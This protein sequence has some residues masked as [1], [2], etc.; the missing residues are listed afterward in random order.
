MRPRLRKRYTA[1]GDHRVKQSREFFKLSPDKPKAILE[2]LYLKVVTPGAELFT[3]PGDKEAVGEAKK[4]RANFC[5]ATVGLEPG[6]ILQSVFDDDITCTVKGERW[7]EF[8]GQEQSLSSSAL[9]I[10]HEK[11]LRLVS[12]RRSGLLEV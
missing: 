4:R 11:G 7:V 6:T 2:L 3:E 5:F 1:F 10:A 8:R 12:S 9:E